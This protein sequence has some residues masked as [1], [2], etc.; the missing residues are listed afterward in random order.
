MCH[1]IFASDTMVAIF[2][3]FWVCVFKRSSSLGSTGTEYKIYVK[4]V[5][6]FRKEPTR[7][8]KSKPQASTPCW[9][10]SHRFAICLRFVPFNVN[11]NDKVV[12]MK[13][14]SG[15]VCYVDSNFIML[16]KT[17]LVAFRKSYLSVRCPFF[18]SRVC[19]FKISGPT[20][21]AWTSLGCYRCYKVFFVPSNL[22]IRWFISRS[23]APGSRAI[24]PS[25]C[26]C[27]IGA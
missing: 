22:Y 25:K 24:Q 10:L 3:Q 9:W 27:V 26:R 14:K 2:S 19:N 16:V 11:G 7:C 4:N 6:M 17:S 23:W 5:V 15:F 21:I 18:V 20:R 8:Q 1:Q 12:I 13:K